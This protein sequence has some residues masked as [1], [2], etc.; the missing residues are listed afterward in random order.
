MAYESVVEESIISLLQ[1]QGY[2]L[3][4]P[5]SSGWFST[6][7]PMISSMWSF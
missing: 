3:V 1:K 7:S 2:E 6:R 5:D 4:E